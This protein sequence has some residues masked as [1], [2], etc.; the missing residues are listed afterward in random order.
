MQIVIRAPRLR[1]CTQ[2][3][4]P[5]EWLKKLDVAR[6]FQNLFSVIYAAVSLLGK[7]IIHFMVFSMN[8]NWQSSHVLLATLVC[9]VL[10]AWATDHI[11]SQSRIRSLQV[12]VMELEVLRR[13]NSINVSSTVF[14]TIP[15]GACEFGASEKGEDPKCKPTLDPTDSP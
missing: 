14:E 2:I 5:A 4:Y 7:T 3:R 8:Y 1:F 12:K 13:L 6:D 11:I 10:C 15:D 9:S